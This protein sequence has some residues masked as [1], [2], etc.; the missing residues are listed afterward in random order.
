MK[1]K[2]LVLGK[3]GMLGSMVYKYLKDNSDFEVKGTERDIFDAEKF[4]HK[5]DKYVI[6]KNYDYI[7][8]CI[9]II[10]PYC[11]DDDLDGVRRAIK[12]NAMFPHVLANYVKDDNTK[13]IQIATD[14]VY[15][16]K[17]GNYKEDIPHDAL[18]V[19][20]KTKSLGEVFDEKHFLNV[21]CSIIGPELKGK[22]SLL[23]WFLNQEKGTELKGFTHHKWNGVTTL[24]FSKLC[25][26][27]IEKDLF[28]KLVEV[29]TLHHFIPN[30][31]VDK[32][33]LLNIFQDVFVTDYQIEAVDD[34]GSPIDRS[35]DTNY[36]LLATIY[37]AQ[38]MK[39]AIE[40]LDQYLKSNK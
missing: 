8:N 27:I 10:K 26:K 16:G 15:S 30:T 1:I 24:Q 14:C 6:V 38:D 36:K 39:S 25:E 23:E 11:N 31:T 9:G 29:S 12:V 20:G 28:N 22:L 17:E 13:V 7:I 21:R 34:I 32:Y 33:E 4:I 5:P 19:Y 35:I 40:E 2:V 3:S 37:P 18:D